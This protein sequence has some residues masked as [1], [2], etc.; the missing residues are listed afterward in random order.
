MLPNFEMG[1]SVFFL[2]PN[3]RKNVSGVWHP[4]WGF[5]FRWM[6]SKLRNKKMKKQKTKSTT[7]RPSVEVGG[8]RHVSVV[9]HHGS[10]FFSFSVPV[11][12]P[13]RV[14]SLPRAPIGCPIS[15]S[16]KV[17][18]TET[19]QLCVDKAIIERL[20]FSWTPNTTSTSWAPFLGFDFSIRT[21]MHEGVTLFFFFLFLFWVYKCFW[22][23]HGACNHENAWA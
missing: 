9:N 13:P 10:A 14:L 17:P 20:S 1:V 6:V 5:H 16:K 7:Q 18:F 23:I 4:R 19:I 8:N 3:G 15:I 2:F 22:V 12:R 21:N 11:A